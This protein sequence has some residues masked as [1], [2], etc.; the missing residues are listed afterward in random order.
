[1]KKQFTALIL[2]LVLVWLAPIPALAVTDFGLVLNGPHQGEVTQGTRTYPFTIT[3]DYFFEESGEI[4]GKIE[5]PTLGSVHDIQ[6]SLK[7]RDLYFKET[8]YIIKGKAKL[9]CVYYMKY[10]P[11]VHLFQGTWKELGTKKGGSAV[12]KLNR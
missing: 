6:G 12:I 4:T 10:S 11:S 8:D 2:S 9:N 1:M 5:W 3:V 7:G